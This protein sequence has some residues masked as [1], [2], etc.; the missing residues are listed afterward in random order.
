VEGDAGLDADRLRYKVLEAAITGLL[1]R[2]F[3]DEEVLPVIATNVR[4][5]LTSI[6]QADLGLKMV[7]NFVDAPR[8]S[9]KVAL[10]LEARSV[11]HA[12]AVDIQWTVSDWGCLAS[13]FV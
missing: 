6:L 5:E 11:P 3:E 10:D 7:L 9:Q 12:C 8:L 1:D 4:A 13:G 2:A